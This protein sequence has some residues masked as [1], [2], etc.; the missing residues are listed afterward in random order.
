MDRTDEKNPVERTDHEKTK[1]VVRTLYMHVCAM[2]VVTCNSKNGLPLAHD[3]FG[4]DQR[5]HRRKISANWAIMCSCSYA[6]RPFL[7]RGFG[8][9]LYVPF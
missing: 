4:P 2:N 9:V 8:S 6:I 1:R 3:N 5:V 7:D